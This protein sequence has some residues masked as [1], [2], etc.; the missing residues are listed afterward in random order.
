MEYSRNVTQKV[1]L[2]GPPHTSNLGNLV[3][4]YPEYMQPGMEHIA[5]Y[6]RPPWWKSQATTTISR[7]HKDVAAKTHLQRLRQIPA[8]DLIVYT[9][10]SGHNGHIGA[11]IYSPTTSVTG[12]AYLGTDDTHNVYAAELTAIQM[13]LTIIE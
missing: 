3:K 12:G 10:G 4:H 6:V 2:L 1:D 11:A 5:A 8:Q 9:D 7:A 13:A